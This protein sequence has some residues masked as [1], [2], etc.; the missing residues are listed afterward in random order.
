MFMIYCDFAGYSYIAIGASK[1]MG[2]ELIRNFNRPYLAVS[3]QDF[4]RRW[5][6]SLSTWFRDYLYIPL[7]GSRVSEIRKYMNLMIVFLVS[8][9]WHGSNWTFVIW[10]FAYGLYQIIG[11]LLSPVKAKV[12]IY[13]EAHSLS[14]G[15][16]LIRIFITDIIVL[17]TWIIFA[18]PSIKDAMNIYLLLFTDFHIKELFSGLI[19]TLGLGV[20]NLAFAIL[21]VII[22]IA[23][24]LFCEKKNCDVDTVL[25]G[26]NVIIRWAFY[27][28]LIIMILLSCN[29][30]SQEFLYQQF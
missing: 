13:A 17:L 25:A 9:L 20:S 8:G 16:K 30:S 1:I 26:T 22:L 27:Y 19:F 18:A 10:G 15:Y 24:D 2:F 6:I 12:Q 14:A 5:H 4:W 11:S 3:V 7:G 23:F 29:L 21:A 28:L